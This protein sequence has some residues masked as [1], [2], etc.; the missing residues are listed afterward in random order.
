MRNKFENKQVSWTLA[1]ALLLAALPFRGSVY[2]QTP[3]KTYYQVKQVEGTIN[4]P[5]IY[6]KKKIGVFDAATGQFTFSSPGLRTIDETIGGDPNEKPYQKPQHIH[7]DGELQVQATDVGLIF[8]VKNRKADFSATVNGQTVTA[9]ANGNSVTVNAGKVLKIKW[10]VHSGGKGFG[11]EF[12]IIRSNTY[13]GGVFTVRAL[14]VAI[15]YE[16]PMDKQK[17]NYATYATTKSVG[18][19]IKTG[20]TS[21]QSTTTPAK[22]SHFRNAMDFK[23]DADK[24]GAVLSKIPNPYTQAIGTILQILAAGMGNASASSQTGSSVTSES[25]LIL[26]AGQQVSYGTAAKLGPGLGDRII[27]LKN[28]RLAWLGNSQMVNV[29]VL[30]YEKI[31]SPTVKTLKDDW[32]DLVLGNLQFGKG[33]KQ[34]VQSA[35]KLGSR[36]GLDAHTILSLFKLD[37]F[38]GHGS[39]ANL[40]EKRF[41]YVETFEPNGAADSFTFFY[42]AA[43]S[44]MEAATSFNVDTEEYSAGFLSFIGLGVTETKKLTA[45]V[46]ASSSQEFHSSQKAEV[47][48]HFYAGPDEIYSVAVYYDRI[49]GTFAFKKVVSNPLEWVSGIARLA[50]GQPAAKQVVTL[51]IGGRKFSTRADAEGRYSFRASNITNGDGQIEVG[52]MRKTVRL[53]TG[54]PVRN[55]ELRSMK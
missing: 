18:T 28:A 31:A 53:Q 2:G 15:L 49:F 55:L 50:N 34:S 14:P 21:E 25:A 27:Y 5:S 4:W 29:S 46:T 32:D 30:G 48:A 44:Y 39:Q 38:Y 42:D 40:D 52:N 8:E 17:Q 19:T 36:T 7:E 33:P 3:E 26:S 1:I 13:G 24:A 43:K 47:G 41:A 10:S 37:P 9:P 16:P 35:P 22:P 6:V 11:N 20:W 45:K 12:K 54:K 23:S 51:T